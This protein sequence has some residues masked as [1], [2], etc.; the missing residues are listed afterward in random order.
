MRAMVA[1]MAGTIAL[2]CGGVA[3]AQ[4]AGA[5]MAG[6]C[7]STGGFD[8]RLGAGAVNGAVA[9]SIPALNSYYVETS[10][11][12]PFRQVEVGFTDDTHRVHRITGM[13]TFDTAEEAQAAFDQA[14]R[15]LDQDDRFIVQPTGDE[16]SAAY[17]SEDPSNPSGFKVE[18]TKSERSVLLACVDSA[19][20]KTARTEWTQNFGFGAMAQAA[21][22]I[23]DGWDATSVAETQCTADG[24]FGQRFGQ[25]M[26]GGS[27]Q[28]FTEFNRI[29]NGRPRFPPFQ[30][31]EA[32]VTSTS[33]VVHEI[34]A[35]A[36][37]PDA[38]SASEAYQA[39]VAAYEANDRLPY[40]NED[41]LLTGMAGTSFASDGPGATSGYMCSS[42][43]T[44]AN[45]ACL[46]PAWMCS[47][48]RLTKRFGAERYHS[49]N[50]S[51]PP[52]AAGCL[53]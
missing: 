5:A 1:A 25:R 12:A 39:L 33:R 34:A 16:E 35:R 7:T 26:R 48:A 49:T 19:L 17:Y 27:R 11:F 23:L 30:H 14:E 51:S 53:A 50:V 8:Q 3:A 32:T 42:A 15:A 22:A 47:G 29:L 31:V 41:R 28:G 6:Y 2:M 20:S 45:C 44:A 24:A 43:S 38:R 13:V 18:L 36:T 4:T 52:N 21:P 9:Q 10:A 37:F 40:R 46:A